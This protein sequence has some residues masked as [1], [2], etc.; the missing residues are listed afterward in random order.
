MNSKTKTRLCA[1]A[2]ALVSATSLILGFG[3]AAL[4]A[5]ANSI[6]VVFKTENAAPVIRTRIYGGQTYVSVRVFGKALGASEAVQ[7]GDIATIVADGVS[8]CATVGQSYITVNDR[9]VYTVNP[10]R[11]IG[12][13]ISCPVRPLAL[14][15]GA[16]VKWVISEKTVEI[17][18]GGDKL[19]APGYSDDD[20]YWM[21]RIIKAEAGG[22]SFEGKIAVGNVI[23]NRV[24]SDEFPNAVYSVIFD[25]RFGIQFSPAYSGSIYN[26]PTQ[27]CYAAAALALEGVK[28]VGDSLYF[29]SSKNSWA[30]RNRPAFG[31]I[32]GHKFYL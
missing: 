18:P 5:E 6:S 30:S 3:S 13:E 19:A 14:A 28:V 32:G 31:E 22:E 20:L 10:I 24:A 26:K 23:M 15:L 4:G 29:A 17:I 2:L 1:I 21:A 8:L 9:Y 25:R 7:S 27:E 11:N 16:G 12:G